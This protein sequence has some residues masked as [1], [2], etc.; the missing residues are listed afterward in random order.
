MAECTV[1]QIFDDVRSMLG[2]TQIS[3][4][5]LFTNNFLLTGSV[6]GGTPGS[7]SLFGEP[8][9]T[10]FSKITGGS[11]RVQPT[12][13]VTLPANTTV[14]IPSTYGLVDF[15]EPEFIEERQA[16]IAVAIASTNTGTPIEV[17]TSAPHGYTIGSMI[18]GAVSGVIGTS[19]PWGNWFATATGASTMTLNG[20]ASDGIA[21]TGG[22]FYP[23]GSFTFTEVFPVDLVPAI[24]GQPG[25]TL[26]NYL[27]ANG[28]LSF[29]GATGNVQLRITYYASGTAPVS[30]NY[31]IWVDNCRDFLAT[32]T[33]SKA[34]LAKQWY[35]MADRLQNKAYGDPMHPEETSLIDLFYIS[36]VMAAQRGPTRRQGPFRDKR[37]KYGTYLLG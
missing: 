21:G 23:E 27:W 35:G 32:A 6:S 9:R 20:S 5:E 16:P 8:Y 28:R 11:K 10:M 3:G 2:D 30:P 1:Q 7:G 22:A 25:A 12:V 24:D 13:Y 29:R 31:T 15:S 37:S 33:A 17:T 14:L 36:Q 18:E 19:A 4:G 26:G 34:A